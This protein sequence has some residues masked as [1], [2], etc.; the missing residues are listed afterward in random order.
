MFVCQRSDLLFVSLVIT[1]S[2]QGW[3][4]RNFIGHGKRGDSVVLFHINFEKELSRKCSV[5]H[6]DF[7][8]W[9]VLFQCGD[10]AVSLTLLGPRQSRRRLHDGRE[11][12]D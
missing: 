3:D 6:G 11:D 9:A 5:A 7:T 4:S 2:S 12:F 8:N 10:M 1:R